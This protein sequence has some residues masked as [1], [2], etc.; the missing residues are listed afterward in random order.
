MTQ[1]RCPNL[2]LYLVIGTGDT[3]G[4]PLTEIVAAAVAGGVDLV[5]LREKHAD[6]RTLY[7]RAGALK[8]VLDAR[9]VPLIVNDRLDVALAVGAA[10]VHLGQDD[11]PPDV[12]RRIMGPGSIVGLSVSDSGEAATADPAIV[13]YTG[14]GAAFPTGTK[15]DAG[16]A[17]GPA[18]VRALRSQVA[19]PSVAI[20][21]ITA[22]NAAELRGTGIEGIAVV[23]AIAG[24]DDPAAAARE[25]RTAFGLPG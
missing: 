23:S 18:G 12:A 5:Q 21:G 24:A 6:T 9:G 16:A 1:R 19:M 25:L 7:R 11:M 17:I 13:D 4:R 10:G 14:I 8:D 20:G 15:A 22:Q 3:G 2:G